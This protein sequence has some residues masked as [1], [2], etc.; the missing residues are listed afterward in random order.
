MLFPTGIVRLSELRNLAQ[1]SRNAKTNMDLPDHIITQREI[2]DDEEEEENYNRDPEQMV[3]PA[4]HRE[5]MTSETRHRKRKTAKASEIT[6]ATMKEVAEDK[7]RGKRQ[8][9]FNNTEQDEYSDD[10][11][12]KKEKSH[13]SEELWTQN[14]QK[15]LE[16]A[17]QQYPKGTSDRW[18]KIAKCVPGKSK[19][20]SLFCMGLD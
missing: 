16:L 20:G 1:N 11:N 15:L 3:I 4:D 10:E 7:C 14:Q 13:N 9:D 6:L 19:V 2:D 8:K 5:T 18:D 17:L 12:R